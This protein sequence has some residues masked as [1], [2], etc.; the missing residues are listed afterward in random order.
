MNATPP[1][2]RAG[3][4]FGFL[5]SPPPLPRIVARAMVC[6]AL[7][8][9]VEIEPPAGAEPVVLEGTDDLI[10][11]SLEWL[12][13]HGMATEISATE[14]E[15]LGARAGT[16]EPAARERHASAGEAAATLAWALRCAPLPGFDVDADA[17]EV[18]AAL[19]WLSDGGATLGTRALLREREQVGAYLDTISAAHWRLRERTRPEGPRTIDLRPDGDAAE[20]DATG[21]TAP[22]PTTTTLGTTVSME[23]WQPGR[24]DWPEGVTPLALATDG[25]MALGG[26]SLAD[27][28]PLELYA[29]LRRVRE[30]HRATL[31]LLGQQ[32]DWDEILLNL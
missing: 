14:R 19:G 8:Q 32:R 12:E 2:T 23:R 13:R 20:G 26:R 1:R 11:L 17:A 16:L 22:D 4:P 7:V 29:A 10:D 5:P 27:A 6:C 3:Q 21:A 15:F 24:Y 30:R 18:A 9:R 31:W 28:A 25:D